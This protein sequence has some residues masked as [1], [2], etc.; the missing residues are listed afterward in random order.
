MLKKKTNIPIY[1][2]YGE[3]TQWPT[4]DFIHCESI[5]VRSKLHNWQIQSHQH[6]ALCQLLYLE[7]GRAQ[8]QLDDQHHRMNDG[9]LLFVPQMCVHAFKFNKNAIGQVITIAYPFIIELN[10]Q[11]DNLESTLQHPAIH[12]LTD[13]EASNRTKSAF[14]SLAIEYQCNA[15]HRDLRIKSMLTEILIWLSRNIKK[16]A[17][18]SMQENERSGQH[19]ATFSRMIEADYSKHHL[20]TYYARKI[21]ITAAHLNIISRQTTGKSA[22]NLIHERLLLEAKRNLVYTNLSISSLSYTLGFADPAYFTRFF[23]RNSGTSPKEFRDQTKTL[24]KNF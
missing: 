24:Y 5:A 17:P 20:V 22:L 21:G 15:L 10:R 12:N 13:D 9:Q 3:Q 19:L 7:S 6:H 1:K 8:I 18:K 14:K 4:S 11:M 2:L 23:K 16:S